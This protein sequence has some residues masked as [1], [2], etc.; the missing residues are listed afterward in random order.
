MALQG[1]LFRY[2]RRAPLIKLPFLFSSHTG[3]I[4]L[5][6]EKTG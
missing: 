2:L 1:F 3:A 6:E 5:I 4:G